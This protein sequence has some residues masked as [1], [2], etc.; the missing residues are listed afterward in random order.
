MDIILKFG[1]HYYES[2]DDSI[3]IQF[4]LTTF[5]AFLGFGFALLLYFLKNRSDKRKQNT[6]Q[7][8]E[9]KN[10]LKYHELLIEN[11]TRNTERQISSLK[12]FKLDQEKDLLD[13]TSPKQVVTNDFKRLI[14]INKDIFDSFNFFNP[15][16]NSWIDYLKN[17][18]T[19]IDFIEGAFDEI[20]RISTDHLALCLRTEYDIKQKIELIPDRFLSFA[21]YLEKQLG[22]ERWKSKLYLFVN[23]S[24]EKYDELSF[25]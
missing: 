15:L 24:I 4:V 10:K 14:H 23:K 21:F 25:Q 18:H 11:L 2:Y 12:Q 7:I 19:N 16:D 8:I 13:F 1:E 5:S 22:E 20:S 3:W 6:K 17:L 9:S